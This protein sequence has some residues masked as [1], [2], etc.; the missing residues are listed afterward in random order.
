MALVEWIG[1]TSRVYVPDAGVYADRG[2]PVEVPDDVAGREPSGE[3]PG[4]GLLAQVDNWRRVP[5]GGAI[6]DGGE[7]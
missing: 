6:G 5:A 1:G 4:V 2:V 3:D 7:D